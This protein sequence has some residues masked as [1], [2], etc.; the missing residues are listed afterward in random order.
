MGGGKTEDCLINHFPNHIFKFALKG[1]RISL[2][3]II[4]HSYYFK[5]LFFISFAG[6]LLVKHD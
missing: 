2:Y 1:H 3:R 5:V 4:Y 6:L